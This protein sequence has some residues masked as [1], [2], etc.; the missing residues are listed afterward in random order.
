MMN[1]LAMMMILAGT[2]AVASV[3]A[4]PGYGQGKG[5]GNGYGHGHG[6]GPGHGFGPD[7]CHLQLMVNDAAKEVGLTEKQEAELLQLHYDHLAEIKTINANN[8]NDCVAARDA[9]I[10][11]REKMDT[12]IKKMLSE[13]QLA[14]YDQFMQERRGPHGHAKYNGHPGHCQRQ[15]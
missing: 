10:A 7:S 5:N 12:R 8:K 13:D 14:K 15:G 4:Q 9:R 1:R 11:S 3:T 2:F 6:R